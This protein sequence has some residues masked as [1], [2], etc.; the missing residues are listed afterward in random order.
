M[1]ILC[2]HQRMLF[3]SRS[4]N[5]V[6]IVHLG[7]KYCGKLSNLNQ[8][9]ALLGQNEQGCW[10]QQ[11]GATANAAKTRTASLQAFFGGRIFGRGL[12]PTPTSDLTSPDFFLMGIS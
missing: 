4:L 1:E 9:I 7:D 2:S 8:F 10:C 3:C 6:P 12:R 11:D 5:F